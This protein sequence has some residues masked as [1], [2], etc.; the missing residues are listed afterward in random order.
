M[1]SVPPGGRQDELEMSL[2][3]LTPERP[4]PLPK[5]CKRQLLCSFHA[6][7]EGSGAGYLSPS[8]LSLTSPVA[9][10][11]W[12]FPTLEEAVK[13][14]QTILQKP[15]KQVEEF[16]IGLGPDVRSGRVVYKRPV[17]PEPPTR[18][19]TAWMDGDDPD[20]ASLVSDVFRNAGSKA[21]EAGLL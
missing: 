13:A 9:E 12:G 19:T 15:M 21:R 14:Q 5:V 8:R 18:G 2:R 20:F 4:E 10:Q 17:N 3:M 6:T 11:M 7:K 1:D 16:L